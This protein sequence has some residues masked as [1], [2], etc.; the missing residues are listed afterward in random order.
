MSARDRIL[1]RLRAAPLMPRSTP[2]VGAYY[3]GR[4][5]LEQAPTT[6]RSAA[7]A[8]INRFRQMIEAAHAEVHLVDDGNWPEQLLGICRAKQINSLLLGDHTVHGERF[9]TH[10]AADSA[11]APLCRRYDT[12]IDSWKDELFQQVDAAFTGCRSAIAATGTLIVWPDSQEPRLMSLVPPVHIALLDA[13]TIHAD[14]FTAM[15]VENWPAG[16]PTNAL[17]IS[18]PSKTADIQQ[19]LAYG[20]HGPKELVILLRLPQGMSAADL[21][22][23]AQPAANGGA[24]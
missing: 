17:L 24:A 3:A 13:T 20:A 9:A 1:G 8:L 10:L 7:L 18:G 11:S 15:Q 19:T 23:A 6:K 21:D 14:L 4:A 5:A 22:D 12:A 16:L 2:D